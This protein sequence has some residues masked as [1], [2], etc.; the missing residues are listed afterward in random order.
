M[1][2]SA[3][4]KL[5]RSNTDRVLAG[6]CGGIAEYL[7][8]DATLIRVLFVVVSLGGGAGILLYVILWVVIPPAGASSGVT[9]QRLEQIGSEMQQKAELVASHLG[10][11]SDD[12]SL[13]GR[14]R[15]FAV[16]ILLLGVW[17]LLNEFLPGHWF[18]WDVFWPLLL[19]VA[20]FLLITKR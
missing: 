12:T 8:I 14:H 2:P 13:G 15:W 7:H 17:L 4:R 19:I 11:R 6:V 1:E 9:R 10:G 18:R 5:Y 20:G 16:I 3:P